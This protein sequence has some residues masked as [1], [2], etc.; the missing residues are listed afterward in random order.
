[1]AKEQFEKQQK[2]SLRLIRGSRLKTGTSRRVFLIVMD[3]VG[4]GS[5][6]DAAEYGQSGAN[7]LGHICQ[8]VEKFKLSNFEK[9]GLG[10]IAKLDGVTATENPKA[11]FGRIKPLTKEN[12]SAPLHW[13]MMG[14]NN[15][16]RMTL[17]PQGLPSKVLQ[18]F[19]E[20]TGCQCVGN[21]MIER[22]GELERL[23]TISYQEH[24]P[25]VYSTT[26]SVVQIII[27][28]EQMSTE[29]LHYLAQILRKILDDDY[30]IGRV[31]AKVF[32]GTEGNFTRVEGQRKDMTLSPPTSDF[33]MTRLQGEDIPV[34]GVG[35]IYDFFSG[36][37][38]TESIKTSNNSEGIEQIIRLLKKLERGFVFANLM[39]FDTLGGHCND[40][41]AFAEYLCQLDESLT[42]MLDLL[43]PLDLLIITSDHGNDPT[44]ETKTH[45][46]EYVPLLFV[47]PDK[48]DKSCSL[49]VRSTFGDI[50]A[51]IAQWFGLKREHGISFLDQQFS[52][53]HKTKVGL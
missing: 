47:Y 22:G 3:G 18:R 14:I 37:G 53:S 50:S 19:Y 6:P 33:L 16:R 25:A 31:V 26:D 9:L 4:I 43:T 5:L 21:I 12:D 20:E 48:Q 44:L 52:T 41:A 11:F 10:N 1:M 42:V 23:R 15:S 30:Y 8:V 46:R 32:T 2:L 40:P 36:V 24:K 45:T 28:E 17:L 29:H 7:T 51:T 35:K 49:G 38:I 27:H 34:I 39:D 13:E